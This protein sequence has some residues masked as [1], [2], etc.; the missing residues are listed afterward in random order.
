MKFSLGG[1]QGLDIF[2][3][4][5]LKSQEIPSDSTVLVDGIEQTVTAGSNNL[6]YDS[7]TDQYNY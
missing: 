6:S 5:Y 1:D 7:G 2:A 4:S 3:A